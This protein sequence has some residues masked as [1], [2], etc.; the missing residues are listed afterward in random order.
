MLDLSGP[1]QAF[2][3]ARR[4]GAEVELMYVAATPTVRSAQG[5]TLGNL[6]ALPDPTADDLVLIP[7]I[8]SEA[9]D[10]LSHVPVD[11]LNRA[12]TQGAVVGS[13]CSAAFALAVSG[14][15]DGRDCT[16]HWKLTDR[17]QSSFPT[18][19][20]QRNRLFVRSGRIITS[21][22]V[23]SGIDMALSLIEE[24]DGPLVAARVARE[25]VV[26]IRRNGDSEQE[27]IFLKFRAHMNP[28]VHRVQDWLIAHPDENPSLE[29]LSDIA[30][31]SPRHLTRTFREAT[32]TTLKAF[33]THLKLEVAKQLLQDPSETVE[34]VALRCGYQDARQLRRLFQRHLGESP[35][36]WQRQVRVHS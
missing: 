27:S 21:A 20:V 34:N 36:D 2:Y 12:Y 35:T 19:T 22:G 7:G 18:A 14:L 15:L 30:D 5:L 1:L 33:S 3:E 4:F 32:G 25:L 9:L 26:Y 23:T 16:T 31:M 17:L 13:V 11:W 28:G 6:Q 10:D 24:R 8:D 29:M